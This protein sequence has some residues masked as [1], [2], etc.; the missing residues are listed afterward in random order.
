MEQSFISKEELIRTIYKTVKGTRDNMIFIESLIKY[1]NTGNIGQC[2]I[3]NGRLV[4]S[5]F[6][7]D[8]RESIEVACPTCQKAEFYSGSV[9][10]KK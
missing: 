7:G 8:L 3:C 4:V 6:K 5:V 10:K 9:T 2:P 1:K